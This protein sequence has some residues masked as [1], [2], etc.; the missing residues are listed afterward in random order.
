[1]KLLILGS[2]MY[3]T[4]RNGTGTGTVLSSIAQLSKEGISFEVTVCSKSPSS[5]QH[6]LHELNRIN[7]KL[8]SNLS[9][10][11]ETIDAPEALAKFCEY[12]FF[13]AAIV[14]L[15]DHLHFAYTKVLMDLG[16]H[17]LVVKPFVTN[18]D[19][20]IALTEIQQSQQVLGYVEFHK[21]FDE[22]NLLAKKLI[23][24]GELGQLSYI[25][26]E[27]SQR[28]SIPK[29]VFSTWVSHTN[30]FQ[31]LGVHYVDLIYFLTNFRPKRT[32]AVESK[33]ILS[34][35]GIE[36]PDAIHVII[37]WKNPETNE[38]FTSALT[39]GWIDPDSTAALSNQSFRMVGSQARF[40]CDQTNRGVT[41]VSANQGTSFP[42]PY[43]SE[44]LPDLDNSLSFSGYG[45]ESISTFIKDVISVESG[46][47]IT[48]DFE[49]KRPTF[50]SSITS[51][52]VIEAVNKSLNNKGSWEEVIV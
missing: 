18:I 2:G 46:V 41:V 27:Y 49:G 21:R 30:I 47:A 6:I 22:T 10:N 24:D 40:E 14:A 9:V 20:A 12:N 36:T 19:D 44:F 51:T 34:K 1:M 35:L 3:V 26:V 11:F 38:T 43:F 17:S 29:D 23:S 50:K 13:D 48:S 42:N 33:G 5:E 25:N 32:L 16:I 7:S 52:A 8:D 15:P 4:G 31:Y 39:I 45:F 37:E 28:I